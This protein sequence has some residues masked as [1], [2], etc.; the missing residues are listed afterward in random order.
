M[1]APF[2]LD[3]IAKFANV[4]AQRIRTLASAGLLDPDGDGRFDDYDVLRLRM[5]TMYQDAGWSLDE[6]VEGLGDESIVYGDLLFDAKGERRATLEEAAREAG[7]SPE[8]L[9]DLR[10]AIG[11]TRTTYD[12]NDIEA[13]RA[14]RMICEAGVPWEAMIEAARVSGDA[15][16]R[17][18]EAEMRLVHFHV[19]EPLAGSGVSDKEIAGRVQWLMETVSPALDPLLLYVHRVH[20][21]RAAVE[22]AFRHLSQATQTRPG[23]LDLTILFVDIALFTPL[24]EVHGDD[25]AADVLD[26]FDS[27]VRSLALEWRGSLVKQIGDAFML[28]FGD[29]VDAVRFAVA[30]D[31][32][33][34]GIEG[35]PA[36]HV[37]IHRGPVVYRLGDF[38][39]TTVNIASRIA[40]LAVAS[41]ILVTEPVAEAA[42]EAEVPV[43]GIG[44]RKVK[45]I[46]EAIPLYRVVRT[47]ARATRRERDPVC[48]MVVGPN[49]A[50]RLMQGG[51]EFAFCSQDCLRRFLEDPARY[52]EAV[53]D[54]TS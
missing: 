14:V 5:I 44:S 6:I 45:G 4:D 24:A 18:A 12:R 25:V 27:L 40:N 39:G 36:I 7:L 30:L 32:A 42:R 49:A 8:R 1:R 47:G 11:V 51:F 19:H 34:A 28:T 52:A 31:E 43:E 3:E 21:L 2:T 20:L 46:V 9:L 23:T 13:A 22:D 41:E 29:A 33:V 16:R 38:V 54:G 53:R 15:L 26:R 37:G 10:T 35:F 50:G 48:G 17:L